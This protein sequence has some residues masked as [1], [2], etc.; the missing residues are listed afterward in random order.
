[1]VASEVDKRCYNVSMNGSLSDIQR[2]IVKFRD[3]RDWKQFHNP[4]D[5]AISLV[6]E[7]TEFLEHFQWKNQ[8]EIEAHLKEKKEEIGDELADVL[9]RVLL[10]AN[11]L[12]IDLY[13]ASKRKLDMNAQ[14]YQIEKSK[15][16]HKKY[17][18]FQDK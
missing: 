3:A 4:K 17:T 7:S 9:Y 15:G 18:E 11:D 14:K 10:I 8:K 1:M 6:L 16:N 5:L 13:D 12:D 2:L